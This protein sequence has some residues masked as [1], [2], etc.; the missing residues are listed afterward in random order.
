[1]RRHQVRFT[2]RQILILIAIVA[3][4]LVAGRWAYDRYGGQTFVQTYYVGDLI[5]PTGWISSPAIVA[6]LPK[7][8]AL[9]KA[10]VTPDVWWL[11]SRSV[12]PFP[13]AVS[14]IVSHTSSG[15]QQVKEWLR[16]QRKLQD[17]RNR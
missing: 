1:M 11:R 4:L 9:L 14:L 3:T 12:T 5:A 10:S 16:H 8:A 13:P 7:Q 17:A 15:H 6:E 2:I